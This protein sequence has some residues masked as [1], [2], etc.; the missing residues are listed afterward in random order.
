MEM[1]FF[2]I[3]DKI[4]QQ[5]YDLNGH[6]GQENLANLPEQTP[7]WLAPHSGTAVVL[8]FRKFPPSIT[9]GKTA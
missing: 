7:H 3:G 9:N 4:A 5:M 1:K 6:P 2:W 8:A